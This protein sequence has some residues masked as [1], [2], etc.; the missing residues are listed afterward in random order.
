MWC[1]RRIISRGFSPIWR[2]TA[3]TVYATDHRRLERG[4][5]RKTA[6]TLSRCL[7][8]YWDLVPSR[9]RNGDW[10]YWSE[11]RREEEGD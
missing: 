6:H 2:M 8:L 9:W 1:F 11:A 7:L 3:F 5:L 4:L 10:G